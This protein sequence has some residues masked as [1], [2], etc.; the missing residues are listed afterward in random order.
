MADRHILFRAEAALFKILGKNLKKFRA[1]SGWSQADL[2]EKAEMSVNFLSAVECGKKFLSPATMVK[3]AEI[4]HIEV[5]ELFKPEKIFSDR[6]QN[7]LNKY[8]EDVISAVQKVRRKYRTV[9]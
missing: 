2:A 7:L 6:S 3:L 1:L 9:K 8:T 5:Y 4:F